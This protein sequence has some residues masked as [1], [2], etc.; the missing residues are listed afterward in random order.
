MP[1]TLVAH[2]ATDKGKVREINEDH[3]LVDASVSLFAVADG[4]G[5]K[6]GG[7]IASQ[8]ACA[9]VREVIREQHEA[10]RRLANDDSEPARAAARQA[11]ETAIQTACSR[12][13][14]LGSSDPSRRGMGSTFDCAVQAGARVVLGH[15]GDGRVY[16]VRQNA[17]YR[18][19][20]DHT[21]AAVQIR[22]G[23]LSVR[24]LP[25]SRFKNVLTR[26]VGTHDSVH[27]DTLLCDLLPGDTLILCSDGVHMYLDDPALAQAVAAESPENLANA[28]VAHANRSGG[29][30]NA[31][32]IVLRASAERGVGAETIARIDAVRA[33]KL[34]RHL[35]YKEQASV[36]AI[37]KTRMYAPGDIIVREGEPGQELFVV[38]RGKVA[39]EQRG[40]V[41]SHMEAGGHFGEMA[42]V[43]EAP[44]SATV[45]ALAPTETLV[46]TQNAMGTLMRSDPVLGVKILWALAQGLSAR[47][48]TTSSELLD[49]KQTAPGTVRLP[50][51]PE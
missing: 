51:S 31:S 1:L 9:V 20:E 25:K 47:L 11:V 21:L 15:V 42:L 34:F 19:T 10:F 16:L 7:N 27:V 2:A 26:T 49:V 8:L 46:I 18:L 13:Y 3:V 39:V 23:V 36:L 37:A 50:F 38:A 35:S 44:R 28:L 17:V 33:M 22:A 12:V 40:S 41:V 29:E 4:I 43:E 45:R 6:R 32:A 14:Q 30:D 24:D 48:R 5:G